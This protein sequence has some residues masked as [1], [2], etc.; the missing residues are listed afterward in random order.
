MNIIT[1]IKTC[2]LCSKLEELLKT[3]NLLYIAIYND[4]H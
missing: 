1:S 2:N 3:C 4:I